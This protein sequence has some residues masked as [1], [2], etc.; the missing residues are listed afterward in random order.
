M[1]AQREFLIPFLGLSNG[2]HPF[3]FTI[4]HLFFN[5]FE[6]S[7]IKEGLFE[8]E[9]Q[10]EKRDRMVILETKGKGYFMA[11]CDRCLVNIQIPMNFEDRVILKLEEANET[12]G[13][14]EVYYLDPKTSHIDISPF[15]Y[16]AIHLNMPIKNVRDC[17]QEDQIFC[18]R[19]VLKNLENTVREEG[20]ERDESPW[21]ELKKLNLD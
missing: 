3:D 13:S 1:K 2:I 18:D 11:P 14:D 21:S 16:E 7:N 5:C 9:V 17:A 10:F 19:E 12:E 4:D 8:V 20:S 15:I 6:T